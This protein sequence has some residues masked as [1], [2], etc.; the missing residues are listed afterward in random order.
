MFIGSSH[1]DGGRANDGSDL[2]RGG[3][4]GAQPA[5]KDLPRRREFGVKQSCGTA[6][7]DRGRTAISALT[8]ASV[9]CAAAEFDRLGR[10]AFLDRYGYGQTGRYFV[11]W[12]AGRYDMKALASAAVGKLSAGAQPL[13]PREF[14]GGRTLQQLFNH[15]GFETEIL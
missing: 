7:G 6:R 14:T 4:L 8:A 10:S 13:A 2:R 11:R 12:A 15:L 5:C 1:S 3:L 9:R